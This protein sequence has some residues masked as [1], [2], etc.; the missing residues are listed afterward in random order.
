MKCIKIT[1]DYRLLYNT[2]ALFSLKRRGNTWN[3]TD[4]FVLTE[5]ERL[6]IPLQ[7][8]TVRL[9]NLRCFYD[10]FNQTAWYTCPFT[11]APKHL[12]ELSHIPQKLLQTG[13]VTN[14][15]MLGHYY[16]PQELNIEDNPDY[17]KIQ[18]KYCNSNQIQ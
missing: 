7:P 8:I 6:L 12:F 2:I 9:H 5:K 15:I 4:F 11:L 14:K 17:I 1:T 10:P 16:L 18:Q 3:D 13:V